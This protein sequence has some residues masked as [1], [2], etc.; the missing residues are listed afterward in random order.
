MPIPQVQRKPRR[1]AMLACVAVIAC[2]PSSAWAQETTESSAV[3]A[4]AKRVLLDPTTYAPALVAYD[5]T[6]RDWNSSQPFFS[7]G[8]LEH[9]ARFTLSGRSDDYPV[10]YGRGQQQILMDALHHVQMAALHNTVENILEHTLVERFPNH[11]KLL[12]VVGWVERGAYA[13]YAGYAL[14]ARHYR[15]WQD[16]QRLAAELGYR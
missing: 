6:M 5:A 14:S 15:Q 13:S 1:A 3:G 16:N 12:R 7:N 8:Y 10:S 2:L 9:N 11:R 4:I